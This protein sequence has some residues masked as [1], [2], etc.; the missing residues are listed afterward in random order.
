MRL[1][2]VIY[3]GLGG[4]GEFLFP[5]IRNLKRK[6]IYKHTIIFYGVESLLS[7]YVKFCKENDIEYYYIDSSKF[8][9]GLKYIK[10]LN[11]INPDQILIHTSVIIKSILYNFLRRTNLVFIDHTSNYVKRKYDWINLFISCL[12]FKKI[13]F[14][15]KFHQQEIQKRFIFR[16]FKK[17]FQLMLPGISLKREN[18]K[19]SKFKNK[20]KKF[21]TLGMASRFAIGKNHIELIQAFQKIYIDL[22]YK[23]KLSLVGTGPEHVKI[24]RFIKK[25]NLN[26]IV[27]LEGF[28]DSKNMK[29]WFN[30]IDIYVH[31]SS[32]E[33]VS[34]SILEAMQNQKIIFAFKILSTKEQLI[35]GCNCGVLFKDEKDFINKFK[36]YLNKKSKLNN[37]KI[38]CLK[39]LKKKYNFKKFQNNFENI[40]G[41]I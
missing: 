27:I 32:G 26:K 18:L 34:R 31:W 19:V 38:N 6:L 12:F 8:F 37:L 20:R 9:S 16:I 39:Q 25:N 28:K 15:A 21:L 29:K 14:L 1:L 10:V 2:H 5:L 33:V 3:S 22:N 41:S 36:K 35:H 30:E 23:L 40:I 4:Q 7:D 11:K 17:K 13:I 24:K